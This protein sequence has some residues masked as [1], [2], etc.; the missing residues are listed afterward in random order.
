[1]TIASIQ[2]GETGFWKGDYIYFSSNPKHPYMIVKVESGVLY[3]QL[4]NLVHQFDVSGKNP[5]IWFVE[6]MV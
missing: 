1:M 3:I 5:L 6:R 2:C 4:P